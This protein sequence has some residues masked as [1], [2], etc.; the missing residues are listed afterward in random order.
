MVYH[1]DGI[2]AWY[3]AVPTS[4]GRVKRSTGTTHRGT[5]KAIERMLVE[6]GPRG[7]RA[8]DLLD[9]VAANTLPLGIL[10]DAYRHNDLSGLRVRLNDV[11]LC[12]HVAGWKAWLADRVKPDTS[13]HY[14]VQLRTLIPEGKPFPRSAF[15]APA[16][17]RW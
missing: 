7:L 8:F 11:D 4:T 16:I 6:L 5:A 10:F 14:L 9:R 2:D 1:P 3:V 12:E 15:T 13:A 17:A